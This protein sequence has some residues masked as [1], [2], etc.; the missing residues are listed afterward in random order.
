MTW[1]TQ[2]E[3]RLADPTKSD[4]QT[5]HCQHLAG[6]HIYFGFEDTYH[7]HRVRGPDHATPEQVA[8]LAFFKQPFV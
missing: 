8:C 3:T 1:P 6:Q 5:D 7:L 2:I 4:P